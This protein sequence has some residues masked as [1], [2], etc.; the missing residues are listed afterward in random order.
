MQQNNKLHQLR[1]QENQQQSSQFMLDYK[2]LL[3]DLLR[4]WWLF[5]ITIPLALGIVFAIH[6][7]SSPIYR[8]SM[9]LLMEERGTENSRESMMEGFGLTPGQR[10]LDNQIAVLTSRDI[11]RQTIDQLDFNISYFAAGRL[12]NTEIYSN[13]GFRIRPDSSSAQILNVPIYLTVLNENQFELTVKSEGYSTIVY[14]NESTQGSQSVIDF[15]GKFNFGE[16]VETPWLRIIVENNG[17]SASPD[18]AYYFQF[19]HPESLTARYSSVL[20]AQKAGENSSI[21]NI[22]VTGHN[23]QKN[24][25]FLNKLSETFINAN[26]EKKNQI[27][28]NTISFIEEQLIIIQ[29]PYLKKEQN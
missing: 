13:P 29:T 11:I 7:Y 16:L 15:K 25:T 27:A 17:L 18:N 8:A 20:S 4:F 19:N 1:N 9:S 24:T 14:N 26:L 23:H 5:A 3:I 28:T 22:S 21:V 10:N 12:K 2:K 6:R